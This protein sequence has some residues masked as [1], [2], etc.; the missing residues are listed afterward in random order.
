MSTPEAA[1]AVAPVEEVKS[2]EA[3]PTPAVEA[4]AP[5]VE[6]VPAPVRPCFFFSSPSC[7][8]YPCRFLIFYFI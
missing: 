3:T 8:P 6:E 7:S 5:K 2:V 1:A 4:E